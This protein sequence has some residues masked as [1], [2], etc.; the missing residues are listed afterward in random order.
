[1][2]ENLREGSQCSGIINLHSPNSKFDVRVFGSELDEFRL[3][4]ISPPNS[5]ENDPKCILTQFL[6]L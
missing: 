3:S 5:S 2:K 1:M 6:V 4:L